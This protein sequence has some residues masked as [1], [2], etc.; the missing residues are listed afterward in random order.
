MEIITSKKKS[1]IGKI[2][3]KYK[4]ELILL[5]GSQVNGRVHPDSDVDIAVLP[6]GNKDFSMEKYSSLSSDLANFFSGKEID[7]TFINRANPLLLKKISDNAMLVFGA[8]KIF[9]EFR[10]K[11][12]KSFQDYLPYF[13]LE[14]HGVRQY[15]KQFSY[16]RR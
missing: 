16:G 13:K 7:L 2:A 6:K 1:L 9:V 8:R 5:F 3:R 15:L 11:A 12:F 10:L 4:L 14:E